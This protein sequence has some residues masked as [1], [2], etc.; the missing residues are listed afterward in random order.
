MLRVLVLVLAA[1]LIAPAARA[2][3]VTEIWK[4]RNADGRWTYT[5]DRREAEKLKCEV[6]TR[7]RHTPTG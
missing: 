5:N 1:M 2:Q 4:C 6:V 3:Q 7:C